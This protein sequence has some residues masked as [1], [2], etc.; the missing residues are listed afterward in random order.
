[1]SGK[2]AGC[3]TYILEKCSKAIYFHCFSHKLN[4]CVQ[5]GL[6]IER[7]RSMLHQISGITNYFKQSEP[8]KRCFVKNIL[9]DKEN[10]I[11][12][13][14]KTK[15]FDVCRTR[16]VARIEGLITFYELIKPMLSCFQEL[17]L[18]VPRD[19]TLW[20]CIHNCNTE[21]VFGAI[22]LMLLSWLG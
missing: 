2:H 17:Q 12:C 20:H 9:S 1:M 14:N 16:W 15:L 4:L 18:W 8:R 10:H 3:Y 5:H 11:I 6:Q 22:L 7:V 19:V 13:T 21:V